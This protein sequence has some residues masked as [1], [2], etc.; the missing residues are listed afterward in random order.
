MDITL[1]NASLAWNLLANHLDAFIAAWEREEWPEIQ[2]HL[3]EEPALLRRLTLVELIK[4]D[5]DYRHARER[6][7]RIEAYAQEFPEILEAAGPRCDLIYEEY[8]VRRAH[9]E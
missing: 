5:L 9:G 6:P 4:A 2:S 7:K 1:D 3:P 8:H